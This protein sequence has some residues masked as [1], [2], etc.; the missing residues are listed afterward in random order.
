MS[1]L[2]R[3]TAR[4]NE[5]DVLADELAKR[6]QE[7]EVEREELGIAERILLRLAEQDR[8]DTEAAGGGGPNESAGGGACGAADPTPR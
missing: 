8:A 7:V 3:I 4:R 5:L 1:D 6:L 2:E